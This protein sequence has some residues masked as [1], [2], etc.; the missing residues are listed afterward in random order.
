MSVPKFGTFTNGPYRIKGIRVFG[1]LCGKVVESYYPMV[2]D[3]GE[4]VIL[5]EY[6]LIEHDDL[7]LNK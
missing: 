3:I 5:P 6:T 4:F 1:N 7:Q 2:Y